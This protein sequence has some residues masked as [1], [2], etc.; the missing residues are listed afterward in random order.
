MDQTK[1][2][3]FFEKFSAYEL[4]ELQD[5][6][7]RRADLA[8]EATVALDR[9]LNEKGLNAPSLLEPLQSPARTEEEEGKH[10]AQE[11]ASSRLL[12]HGG[13][14]TACKVMV[15]LTFMAPAQNLARAF[16]TGAI[17][18]GL[19]VAVAG[20][21]GYQVGRAITKNI[22]AEGDV[23]ISTKRKKLWVMFGVLWPIFFV[24]F[25]A[26]NMLLVRN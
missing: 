22:C 2:S 20:Y 1:L 21:A 25:T 7:A 9:V 4:D 12:W 3:Y 13:L 23:K 11:L 8:D 5:L 17:W 10:T 15:A 6:V 18:A 26:S 24:T 16:S 14:S 19:L